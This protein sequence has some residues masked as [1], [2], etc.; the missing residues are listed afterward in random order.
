VSFVTCP[1]ANPKGPFGGS[2]YKVFTKLLD[3]HL[4]AMALVHQVQV[5]MLQ[6]YLQHSKGGINWKNT[7]SQHGSPMVE[8]EQKGLIAGNM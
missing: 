7:L 3:P 4:A 6:T 8:D 2:S 1:I 5:G